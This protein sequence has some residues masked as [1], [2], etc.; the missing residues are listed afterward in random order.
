MPDYRQEVETQKKESFKKGG[1][2]Y[3]AEFM[4]KHFKLPPLDEIHEANFDFYSEQS[5]GAVEEEKQERERNE[6]PPMTEAEE[7]EFRWKIEEE[8]SNRVFKLYVNAAEEALNHVLGQHHLNAE[9]FE[10][11]W[12]VKPESG[13]TWKDA[14]EQIMETMNGVGMFYAPSLKEFYEQTSVK[15][16]KELVMT[17]IHW[18]AYYPEL[19]G[20]ARIE[21]IFEES[22]DFR[23]L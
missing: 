23:Y 17:H 19:Y 12:L 14:A 22:F 3:S 11:N 1:I 4:K 15:S 9:Y 7:Q 20:T 10:G 6:E 21:R 16:F 5:Y 18:A 8:V 2:L 13:K